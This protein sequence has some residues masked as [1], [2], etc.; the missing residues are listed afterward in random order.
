[1]SRHMPACAGLLMAALCRRLW[2]R[3]RGDAPPAGLWQA[4]GL[5]AEARILRDE[6]G[7]AHIFA[8]T[9]PD[10]A[11]GLG[12][13]TAQD[14]LWQME[15]MRRL[16]SGRIA[17]VA[18]DRK[19]DGIGLHM[20]GPSI[21]ALD[22]FY[23]SL[24]MQ[25][26]AREELLVQSKESLGLLDGFARGVNAWV[27][28]LR[29]ADYPPEFLLAGIDP[30][31]WRPEDSLLIGKLIGW[32]LSLAFLAKPILA[33]LSA[34]PALAWLLPPGEGKPTILGHGPSPDAAGLDLLARRALGLLGPG[35]GSNSWVLGGDRT[36]SGKPILCND[37]HLLLG[38]PALWYP[39]ALTA[40]T[41]QVIGV[42]LAGVPA[43]LIGRNSHL[44]WGMTAVMADDGDYYRETLDD[45]G[46]HYLRAGRWCPVEVTE[47][48]FRVR[49]LREQV[50]RRLR[51]VR[52]EGVLCPLFPGREGEPPTSYRWIGLEPWQ[53]LDGI[54]GMNRAQSV[55]EF[56]AAV[57][58]FAV[59]AQNVVVADSQGHFG[60]YC[61]GRFPRRGLSQGMPFI[62]DGSDPRNAW[63]GYLSWDEHPRRMNPAEGFIV[64]ANNRVADDLPAPIAA[65]YWEPGYRASRIASLLGQ[66]GNA[67]LPDMACIQ[68]DVRSL[69]A[70]AIVAE[71]VRP[72]A[73]RLTD[74][75]A[76]R[77]AD[78]LLV[79]DG[80]AKADS[81]AAAI[82]HLFYQEL[83]LQT[84]RPPMERHAPGLFARYL[85]TLHLAVPA[86]DAALLRGEPACFPDGL[87]PAV[88]RA[89]GAAWQ[90]ATARLGPEPSAW[91]WGDLHPLTFRH[92]FGRGR[93]VA[94][95]ILVWLF[96]LNRGPFARPGDGMTVNLGAF[97]LT[98]PFAVEVGASF[99]H[100]VDLD[101]PENSRWIVA[102]GVSGDP[103][104]RHYA[105]QIPAWL[106][107]ETRPM[108]FLAK[109]DGGV[110]PVLRLVP[111]TR[112]DCAA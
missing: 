97:L 31:P 78:L 80:E 15:A 12:V 10:L 40:P 28:N 13:A 82:Y 20:A 51:F 45:A 71:I 59:P 87:L 98:A 101:A 85:S 93:G 26:A 63:G 24:R 9:L 64:T 54:L 100:I 49:G 46:T 42:T 3:G 108:R 34:D 62:L 76:M 44:A 55:E 61:A 99:R 8:E 32:L 112:D 109:E 53:G 89:L 43:V 25:A 11:F 103:R 1:M 33:A 105:D 60:Y 23:R 111:S 72:V 16:A 79:W 35:T 66:C 2:G 104:S 67:Y 4:P 14:R 21:L 57:Q 96:R 69:Q 106:A 27:G 81:P 52:H 29:S 77:A 19:L 75:R 18:G 107:G 65:G 47:E 37:P 94:S 73:G 95:R 84:V 56:E 92:L 102:G 30:E 38:L 74:P 48:T 70:A 91:R 7:V 17:E 39:V 83:L 41:L 110:G 5:A 90:A 68:A 86:V 36:A 88:E 6:A 50:R 22:Q 58:A